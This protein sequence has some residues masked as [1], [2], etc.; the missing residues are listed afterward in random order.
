MSISAEPQAAAAAELRA[1]QA[2][3]LAGRAD[4]ALWFLICRVAAASAKFV[5]WREIL[6]A[7]GTLHEDK[8]LMAA[9]RTE[10]GSSRNAVAAT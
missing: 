7:V 9:E 2:F 4:R 3:L 6:A 10:T 8:L 1:G 5:A